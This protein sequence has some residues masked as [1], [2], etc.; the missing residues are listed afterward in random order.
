MCFGTGGGCSEFVTAGCDFK[1]ATAVCS[2]RFPIRT[3]ERKTSEFPYRTN[4]PIDVPSDA[5]TT[6]IL[7]S[8]HGTGGD[9]DLYLRNGLSAAEQA[10][11]LNDTLII[12]PQF[13]HAREHYRASEYYRT[14]LGSGG[15]PADLLYWRGWPSLR[16]RVR[17][18]GPR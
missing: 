4:R 2:Q 15:F 12:A 18:E 16:S 10:S 13:L 3:D 6:W 7:I 14:H 8:L 5:I 1:D 9:G 17:G 11:A